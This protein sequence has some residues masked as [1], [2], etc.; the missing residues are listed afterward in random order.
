MRGEDGPLTLDLCFS[1]QADLQHLEFSRERTKPSKHVGSSLPTQ[2]P[3]T[4][5]DHQRLARHGREDATIRRFPA[6][7]YL[8]AVNYP[9]GLD[10]PRSAALSLTS[11]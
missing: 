10:Y 11:L 3:W 5:G 6:E 1:V 2:R 4:F 9:D 8:V 7:R